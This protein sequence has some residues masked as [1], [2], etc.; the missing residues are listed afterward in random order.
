MEY[1]SIKRSSHDGHILYLK[2]CK[3]CKTEYY[4]RKI[5]SNY[6]TNSCRNLKMMQL[7]KE[8]IEK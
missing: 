4:A 6:C 7:K 1:K 5:N 8:K 2:D 3:Y